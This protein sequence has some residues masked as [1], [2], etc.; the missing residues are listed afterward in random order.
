MPQL[1]RTPQQVLRETRR[2]LYYIEFGDFLSPWAMLDRDRNEVKNIPEDLPGRKEI[3]AWF[4][5][6][7]PQVVLEDLGPPEGSGWISGCIGVLMRV[8]FDEDSLAKFCAVWENADGSSKD[9]RW[10]CKWVRYNDYVEHV[11]ELR[12]QRKLEKKKRAKQKNT[13]SDSK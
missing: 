1:I 6:E 5:K 2:D 11:K 8:D 3:L 10:Q 12:V 7:C 13:P 4:A 9:K